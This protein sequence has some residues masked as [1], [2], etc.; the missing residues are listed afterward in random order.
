[1]LPSF[2]LTCLLIELTPGPN[3]SYLAAVSAVQGRAAGLSLVAGVALGLFIIGLV[4]AF[5]AAPW[6]MHNPPVYHALRF[7]GIGYL[8][9]LAYESWRAAHHPPPTGGGNGFDARYFRRGFITNILNPKAIL[10]YVTVFPGFIDPARSASWQFLLLLTL[11]VT[12]ATAVHLAIA[13]LATRLQPFLTDPARYRAT[14][15]AFAGL[16]CMVAV[17]FAW[18][19][20]LT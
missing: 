3:M 16:L 13:L 4:V 17:W 15:Y 18:S 6:I 7:V 10:F 19:T 12:M 5:G 2:L 20:R 8:L 11:S 9:W 1:M 14:Q